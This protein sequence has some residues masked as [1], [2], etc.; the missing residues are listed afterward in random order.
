LRKRATEKQVQE[1]TGVNAG[2]EEPYEALRREKESRVV[3]F[4]D[5]GKRG[6]LTRKGAITENISRQKN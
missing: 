2:N 4:L 5:E 6:E 3:L 1:L